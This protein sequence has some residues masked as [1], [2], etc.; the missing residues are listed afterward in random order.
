MGEQVFDYEDRFRVD[1]RKL[2]L[3]V[4]GKTCIEKLTYNLRS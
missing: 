4:V 2:E 3:M 1:R